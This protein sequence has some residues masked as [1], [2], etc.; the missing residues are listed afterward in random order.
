MERTKKR[1]S[2]DGRAKCG[3]SRR[4]GTTQPR[5]GITYGKGISRVK[6]EGITLSERSQTRLIED[7]WT[8]ER[9]F[10]R[11]SGDQSIKRRQTAVV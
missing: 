1:P 2:N 3:V 10:I 5:E 7:I 8:Y 6:L 4:W 9:M 11:T